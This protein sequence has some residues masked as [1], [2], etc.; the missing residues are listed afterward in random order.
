MS[1]KATVTAGDV[2]VV[3]SAKEMCIIKSRLLKIYHA[4]Q[5]SAQKFTWPAPMAKN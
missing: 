3:H 5:L 2:G 4:V 1:C